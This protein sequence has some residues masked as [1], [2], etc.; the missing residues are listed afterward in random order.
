MLALAVAMAHGVFLSLSNDADLGIAVY[1]DVGGFITFLRTVNDQQIM[2]NL[3]PLES[4]PLEALLALA[5][6]ANDW[7]R[8]GRVF[9]TLGAN[10]CP[11]VDYETSTPSNIHNFYEYATRPMTAKDYRFN[12]V[13]T[14]TLSEMSDYLRARDWTDA[15][16]IRRSPFMYGSQWVYAHDY[17]GYTAPCENWAVIDGEK[18]RP[19]NICNP[20]YVWQVFKSTGKGYGVSDDCNAFYEALIKSVGIAGIAIDYAWNASDMSDDSH[21]E[22]LYYDPATNAWYASGFAGGEIPIASSM[23]IFIFRPPAIWTNFFDF[24]NPINDR[25][26]HIPNLYHKMLNV[27]GTEFSSQLEK[28]IPSSE[29]HDWLFNL[30]Q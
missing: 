23:H 25:Y 12:T 1:D 30:T 15:K 16:S 24:P 8:F 10:A 20:D 17:P 14:T 28:G 6:R 29:I 13:S 4:Y 2:S 21:E 5:W 26:Q 3:A 18:T 7:G 9:N 19:T 22:T 27:N 11:G